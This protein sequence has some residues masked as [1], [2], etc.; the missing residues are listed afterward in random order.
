MLSRFATPSAEQKE[1]LIR[2]THAKNTIKADQQAARVM[3]V[4]LREKELP[5]AFEKHSMKQLNQVLGDL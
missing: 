3:R 4:Y 5:L 1:E 2:G